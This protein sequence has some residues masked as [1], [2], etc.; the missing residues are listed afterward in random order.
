MI[1][2][3]K[4]KL[5]EEMEP[6]NRMFNSH[7]TLWSYKHHAKLGE[8][9]SND[10]AGDDPLEPG[11]LG[12]GRISCRLTREVQGTGGWRELGQQAVCKQRPTTC[13]MHTKYTCMFM[14][15]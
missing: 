11:S 12:P 3:S 1:L 13:N 2:R 14:Q 15:Y 10:S 4:N 9:T 5:N 7:E 8:Y 6:D